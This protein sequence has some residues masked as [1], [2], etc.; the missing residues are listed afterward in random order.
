MYGHHV[1]KE[2]R[3]ALPPLPPGPRHVSIFQTVHR[4]A[5]LDLR[6]LD[7]PALLALTRARYTLH[8]G[9]ET[10]LVAYLTRRSEGNPFYIGELLRA[11]GGGTLVHAGSTR[12]L[13]DLEHAAVPPLLRQVIDARVD[14]LGMATRDLILAA[15]QSAAPAALGTRWN[16]RTGTG[17]LSVAR[18]RSCTTSSAAQAPCRIAL[19]AWTSVRQ[20]RLQRLR[21][22]IDGKW[23]RRSRQLATD[24]VSRVQ[25][26]HSP[27]SAIAINSLAL[28]PGAGP[29]LGLS[30]SG[31]CCHN[32]STITYIPTGRNRRSP[33]SSP[34]SS[35][36]AVVPQQDYL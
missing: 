18:W 4:A 30:V 2:S 6:P 19:I 17:R 9:D 8:E 31:S 22:G 35:I 11:G 16:C 10:R 14:R 12:T 29:Q 23:C 33:L 34:C 26:R 27:T 5:R 3:R 13:G 7:T 32:S 25:P 20:R 21:S 28:H 36:G 15:H 1:T 24:S